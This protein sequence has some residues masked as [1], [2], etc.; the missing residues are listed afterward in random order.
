MWNL[1]L[2]GGSSG[3]VGAALACVGPLLLEHLL[4]VLL[5]EL[6]SVVLAL[7]LELVSVVAPA[8][9]ERLLDPLLSMIHVLLLFLVRVQPL[10]ATQLETSRVFLSRLS[11]LPKGLLLRGTKLLAFHR[12]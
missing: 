5:P 10:T 8:Q 3:C 1:A 6:H 12:S 7:A 4:S 9:I 2:V 11:L